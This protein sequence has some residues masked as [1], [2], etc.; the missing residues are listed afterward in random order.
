M[1]RLASRAMTDNELAG[2]ECPRCGQSVEERFYG[3]CG[4]CRSQLVATLGG[5]GGRPVAAERFEPPM[6]VVPN[7]VATKE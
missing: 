4:A 6:H 7:Q 2:F 1:T 3:P 5:R